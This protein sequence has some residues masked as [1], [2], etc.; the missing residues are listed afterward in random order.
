MHCVDS[1]GGIQ[2]L[3]EDVR[4]QQ[5]RRPKTEYLSKEAQYKVKQFSSKVYRR[6]EGRETDTTAELQQSKAKQRKKKKKVNGD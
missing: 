6:T 3:T 5:P 4:S 1:G 2:R